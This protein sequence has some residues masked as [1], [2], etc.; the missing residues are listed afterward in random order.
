MSEGLKKFVG[1][2]LGQQFDDP[3]EQAFCVNVT[4]IVAEKFD[5]KTRVVR[6]LAENI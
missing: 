2:N 6:Y 4:V 3:V 1:V 5:K